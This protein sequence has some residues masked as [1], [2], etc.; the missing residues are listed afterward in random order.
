[1]PTLPNPT[2]PVKP[3]PPSAPPSPAPRPPIPRNP[4]PTPTPVN[5][6]NTLPQPKPIRVGPLVIVQVLVSVLACDPGKFTTAKKKNDWPQR[7]GLSPR[8]Q[9]PCKG[10]KPNVE[11]RIEKRKIG[12]FN[13]SK[14]ASGRAASSAAYVQRQTERVAREAGFRVGGE[15][16]K[17]YSELDSPRGW[18]EKIKDDGTHCF[19]QVYA[20]IPRRVCT[21]PDGSPCRKTTRPREEF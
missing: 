20:E 19:Y 9:R 6:P 15:G 4:F 11:T 10:G 13:V 12:R 16:I 8:R 14:L 21:C 3:S 5:I 1:M 17:I 2:A 18:L 7:S